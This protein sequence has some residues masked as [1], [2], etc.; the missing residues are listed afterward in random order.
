M[1]LLDLQIGRLL[2]QLRPIGSQRHLEVEWID[3]IQHVTLVNV[4]IV[5]DPQF[6]D[7]ARN[8]RRY[9]CDLHAHHSIPVHGAVT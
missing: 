2:L 6:R 7:L 3:H 4:L 8:L 5:A 9:A 1:Y